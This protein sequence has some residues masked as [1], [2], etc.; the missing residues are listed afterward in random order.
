MFIHYTL[1]YIL[2]I[3]SEIMKT[4]QWLCGNMLAMVGQCINMY[5]YIYIYICVNI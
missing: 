2:Y 3:Y 5:M 1:Y 4:I